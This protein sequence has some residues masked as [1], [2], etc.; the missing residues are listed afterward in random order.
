MNYETST[1]R[2]DISV[3]DIFS[4]VNGSVHQ[5]NI[6][7]CERAKGFFSDEYLNGQMGDDDQL[8]TWAQVPINYE[9]MGYSSL[10]RKKVS[11]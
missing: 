11:R 1:S 3:S 10:G 8:M 6:I 7:V 9:I 2:I 5:F 4:A